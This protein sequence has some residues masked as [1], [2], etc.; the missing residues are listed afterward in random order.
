MVGWKG[1]ENEAYYTN[2]KL[3]NQVITLAKLYRF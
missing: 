2:N 1:G 3:A